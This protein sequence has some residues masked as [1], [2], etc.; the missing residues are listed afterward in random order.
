VSANPSKA[1]RPQISLD[2]WK[3]IEKGREVIRIEAEAIAHLEERIGESFAQAVNVILS[4]KGRV[5]VTGVGKSGIIAKKIASTLA[6]TGTAALFLH[7]TEGIHGDLGMVLKD[8][9]VLCISKSGNTEELSQ[10][11][12]VFKRIGVPVIAMTGNPGSPLAER[13]DMVLDVSVK[14]EACPY[15]LAPTA[16]TTAALAMGDALAMALLERR[17]FTAE[18]FALLHPGGSLGKKL[19]LKIDDVMAMGEKVA[20]VG[21]DTPLKDVIVE[22]TS[23]RLGGTGVVDNEGVLRGIITDG[24]LRRLLEKT[25]DVAHLRAKDIMTPNPK[26]VKAGVLAAVALKVMEDHKIMQVIVVDD[27]HVPVGMV[28]LHELLRAGVA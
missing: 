23:K 8:D 3:S 16:S 20:K 1:Y 11:I 15:D 5:I 27:H 6:S 24:D 17:H 9:V 26:T 25:Q 22:I 19:W 18:D 13:A 12:P 4:C 28:H 7:P 2:D 14:E 21:L 10:L